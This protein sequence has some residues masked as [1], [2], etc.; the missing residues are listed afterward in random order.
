MSAPNKPSQLE[1]SMVRTFV[2]LLAILLL[3]VSHSARAAEALFQEVNWEDLMPKGWLPTQPDYD[4]F[5]DLSGDPNVPQETGAPVVKELDQ[6]RVKIPGFLVPV[7]VQGET[8]SSALLVPYFGACIHTP[9]PPSNQVV[10]LKL[11]EPMSMEKLWEMGAVWAQGTLLA[12]TQNLDI[13]Q[14]GY[15]LTLDALTPYVDSASAAV[16]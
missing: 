4:S 3:E 12:R 8:V 16:D 2:F 10:Y 11:K 14:A 9:P 5:F 7:S 1:I 15:E 13:A 6:K